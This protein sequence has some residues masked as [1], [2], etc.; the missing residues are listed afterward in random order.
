MTIR[1]VMGTGFSGKTYFIS[2]TF[3]NT[4]ILSV[5]E[6]Q[7]NLKNTENDYLSLLLKANDQ[8]K[9]DWVEK[10]KNHENVILE[11]TLFKAK[12]EKEYID[13]IREVSDD[14]IDI[15]VMQPSKEQ[16]LINTDHD[17][18]EVKALMFD[19]IQIEI[20][21][22]QEG[23]AHVYVVKDNEVEDWT[24]KVIDKT[25]KVDFVEKKLDEEP[26]L[27][28][29]GQPFKHICECCGK[30]E[31][32]TSKEAFEK[33]WD[34]PGEGAIFPSSTFGI[35]SPRTCGDCDI[36]QTAYWAVAVE[37]KQLD[38]LSERQIETINR[39]CQ[40]PDIY[41]EDESDGK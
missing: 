28:F 3:P 14:L 6:Y 2:K 37:G 12:E 41:K 1:I 30:V 18:D 21:T 25:S 39:I 7:R 8:I 9:E 36:K 38:E 11:H 13:A 5:G 4:E 40:E 31:I 27:V 35:L 26:K 34:Y 15:Y 23:F 22:T 19:M 32:L 20:P 24:N 17:E 33:G 29:G 16:L 10:I